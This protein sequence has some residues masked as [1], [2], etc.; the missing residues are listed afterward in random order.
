MDTFNEWK[1]ICE[2][3]FVDALIEALC[4]EEAYTLDE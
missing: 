1:D 4:S 2:D 3:A